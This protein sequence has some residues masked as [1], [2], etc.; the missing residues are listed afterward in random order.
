MGG[1]KK[2]DTSF[3]KDAQSGRVKKTFFEKSV[4]SRPSEKARCAGV[5]RRYK[6][7]GCGKN[8]KCAPYNGHARIEI[9]IDKGK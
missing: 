2:A 8:V 6:K 9:K 4:V 1:I 3:Q 7:G 5:I